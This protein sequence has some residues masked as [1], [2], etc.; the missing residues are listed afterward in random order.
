MEKTPQ[1]STQVFGDYTLLDRIAVGGMAEIFKA[2]QEGPRGFERILVIKRILQHLSEDQE[3]KQMFDD[4]AKIAAQLRHANIVQIFELGDVEGTPY[5]AMEYVEGKNLRDLTR[6][7]Q[8]KGLQLTVEQTLFIMS[9]TLR[10]LHF[11]H[12]RT[13]SNGKPLEIIHRD[14][15]PQNIILSYEGEVKILD[16]GIAKAA[17]R[18]SKTEA[19]VLKGKFSY[20]A[21]EQASGRQVTQST[22]IYACGVILHELLTGERLFRAETDVE[23]IERVKM[24]VVP[25]PSERNP[26]VSPALDA[27][28]LKCLQ[29]N[30]EKRYATAGEMH[31]D[32]ARH[33]R[34]QGMQYGAQ[35]L[36]AFMKTLFAEFINEERER[37][38]KALER[39]PDRQMSSRSRTHIAFK[40]DT[41]PARSAKT[42]VAAQPSPQNNR[43]L[44]FLLL[45]LF[46]VSLGIF[47]YVQI[48]GT[49][50]PTQLFERAMEKE[51][52]ILPL[53][54]P[55][56]IELPPLP[57]S[58]EN[59]P[60]TNTDA[61]G[62]KVEDVLKVEKRPEPTPAP[63]VEEERPAEKPVETPPSRQRI[64][65]IPLKVGSGTLDV[66]P[67]P[68]GYA[69]LF[70][71]NEAYGFV[72]GTRAT[73][74]K[75]K[76][77]KHSVRCESGSRTYT[78]TVTINP[79]SNLRI[80]CG[81]LR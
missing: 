74:I 54:R 32:L 71:N 35:E 7:L 24:G 69:K 27:I 47:L 58:S 16:F 19:G 70:I 53:S 3:F 73:G 61:G 36:S 12:Q 67:P 39:I 62:E 26:Q 81:Q 1:F 43:G 9:E 75:L 76:A 57:D 66:L 79:D 60:E 68:E 46:F 65:R 77:G 51:K 42:N 72:P 17:S 80:S 22:D 37:L 10:G 40:A 31:A 55:K 78:G 30:V 59:P 15:S 29:R 28:I 63:K 45:I 49:G 52:E 33:M 50:S 25:K 64:P 14:M 21:P 2:R 11:A 13:D 41:S 20:M 6:A 34:E 8:S 44:M 48:V 18:I 23:T 56:P 4:E 38:R 5:I